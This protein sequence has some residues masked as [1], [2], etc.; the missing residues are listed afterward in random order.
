[1]SIVSPF[2]ALANGE[3]ADGDNAELTAYNHEGRPVLVP[4]KLRRPVNLDAET[5]KK[6]RKKNLLPQ[7]SNSKEADQDQHTK[8][9]RLEL[10]SKIFISDT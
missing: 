1:M 9:S 5:G 3:R 10:L 6:K 7:N 2:L 8:C 4:T